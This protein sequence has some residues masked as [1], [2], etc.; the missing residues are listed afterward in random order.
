MTPTPDSAQLWLIH[1]SILYSPILILMVVHS[2]GTNDSSAAL[3]QQLFY[4]RSVAP[5]ARYGPITVPV[6]ADHG[7]RSAIME[8]SNRASMRCLSIEGEGGAPK[9]TREIAFSGQTFQKRQN[10]AKFGH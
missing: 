6:R 10:G 9:P 4:G 2:L 7:I 8:N 3:C 1:L 5:E